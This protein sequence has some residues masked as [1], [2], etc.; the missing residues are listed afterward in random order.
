MVGRKIVGVA[1]AEHGCKRCDQFARY[2]VLRPFAQTAD[3]VF[4]HRGI[5]RRGELVRNLPIGE[6]RLLPVMREVDEP[7]DAFMQWRDHVSALLTTR[8]PSLVPFAL[9]G[10]RVLVVAR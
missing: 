8:K 10:G 1:K 2:R 9:F 6:R 5:R 4:R 7:A 3:Q